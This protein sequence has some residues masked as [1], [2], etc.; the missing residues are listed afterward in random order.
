M[1]YK[2]PHPLPIDNTVTT[3][4]SVYGEIFPYKVITYKGQLAHKLYKGPIGGM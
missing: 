1:F 2:F 4:K 3:A